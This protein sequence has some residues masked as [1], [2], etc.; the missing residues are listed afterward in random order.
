MATLKGMKDVAKRDLI[1][2]ECSKD[3][4]YSFKNVLKLIK[5]A[6][7]EVGKLSPFDVGYQDLSKVTLP[8]N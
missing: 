4:N 7:S 8:T 6:Y 5:A 1:S 3:V 2:F